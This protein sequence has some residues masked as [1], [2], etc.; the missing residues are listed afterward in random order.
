MK[1]LKKTVSFFVKIFFLMTFY[2]ECF[3]QNQLDLSLFSKSHI[4][5]SFEIDLNSK[6]KENAGQ[7]NIKMNISNSSTKYLQIKKYSYR[8]GNNS[9]LVE[10]QTTKIKIQTDNGMIKSSY[11]SDNVFERDASATLM[12]NQYDPIINKTLKVSYQMNGTPIDTLAKLPLGSKGGSIILSNIKGWSF[13]FLHVPEDF[14]WKEKNTWKDSLLVD[15]ILVKTQY[16]VLSIQN[17]IGL[18]SIKGLNSPQKVFSLRSKPTKAKDEPTISD[19][20]FEGKIS[21]NT[22]N[23]LIRELELNL[24]EEISF[25]AMGQK[26]TLINEQKITVKNQ[27][28]KD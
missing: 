26:M 24:N 27:L 19:S 18:L 13:L 14:V 8:L 25:D 3:S 10:S 1:I 2:I 15:N 12:A 20:I 7:S 5:S 6:P 16:S 17:G 21:V 4:I 9:V 28:I 11:D 23:I 22:K